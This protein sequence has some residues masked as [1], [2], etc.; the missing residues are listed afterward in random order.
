MRPDSPVVNSEK[1]NEN[2]DLLALSHLFSL[3]ELHYIDIARKEKIPQVLKRWPLLA[4]LSPKADFH[5][6]H[7]LT[8]NQG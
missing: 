1:D 6:D 5:P 2:D 8:H 4:E 7:E 3:P